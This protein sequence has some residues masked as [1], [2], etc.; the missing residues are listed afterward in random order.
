MSIVGGFAIIAE[1]VEEAEGHLP[2][3]DPN[4][5]QPPPAA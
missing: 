5:G 4:D 1:A 3:V 2:P